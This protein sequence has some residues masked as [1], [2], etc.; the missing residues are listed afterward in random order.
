M[1]TRIAVIARSTISLAAK[2]RPAKLAKVRSRCGLERGLMNPE[3]GI[4]GL[5]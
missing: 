4:I 2:R 5:L 3:I 1:T